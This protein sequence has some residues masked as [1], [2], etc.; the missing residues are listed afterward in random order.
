[1][2]KVYTSRYSNPEL[3]TGKYTVVGITRGS[4]KFP[5]GYRLDGNIIE[6]APPGWLFN[7]YDREKFTQQYFRNIDK[8]G[9]VK[10]LSIINKYLDLGK[11]VVLCCYEDVRKPNEWCH[12]LVFS[13]WL[14]KMTGEK[15]E[16][17]IDPSEIKLPKVKNV[18]PLRNSRDNDVPHKEK[19]RYAD[20]LQMTLFD[21]RQ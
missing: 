2:L 15:I 1:M 18:K 14:E 13:E 3:M 11:D 9:I 4:P 20:T 17:L 5:L 21:N 19:E 12:R 8:I 7:E 10:I 6:I 16:E